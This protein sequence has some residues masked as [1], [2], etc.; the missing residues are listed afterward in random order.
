MSLGIVLNEQGGVT[1]LEF[2]TA[3]FQIQMDTI[4]SPVR[5]PAQWRIVADFVYLGNCSCSETQGQSS[6]LVVDNQGAIEP[7]SIEPITE[8]VENRSIVKPTRSK[9]GKGA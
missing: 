3:H 2:T 4:P 1:L 5:P 6:T 9:K 7:P 8:G